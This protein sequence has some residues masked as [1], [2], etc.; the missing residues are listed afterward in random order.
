M[1]YIMKKSDLLVYILFC[2]VILL[3]MLGDRTY[4][5]CEQSV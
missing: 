1:A 4:D 5:S 2:D 3:S